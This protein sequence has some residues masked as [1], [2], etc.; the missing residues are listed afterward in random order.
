MPL[1]AVALVL[2]TGHGFRA[3][4]SAAAGYPVRCQYLAQGVSGEALTDRQEIVLTPNTCRSVDRGG[5]DGLVTLAHERQHLLGVT[6]EQEADCEAI[7]DVPRLARRL[8][9]RVSR[10]VLYRYAG[11]FYKPCVR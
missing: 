10:T 8:G 9:F 2:L 1:V 6:D 7:W 3:D 4:L 11:R 5:L